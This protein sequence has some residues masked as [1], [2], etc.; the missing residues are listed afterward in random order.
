MTSQ[1][2]PTRIIQSL[3]EISDGY[4]V[5][6]CDLWGCFHNGIT[7]FAAAVAALQAYRARGGIV[8]LLTN[9]P[10]PGPSVLRQ[11]AAMRAPEDAWD[12]I[13][14][15]GDAT[16]AEIASGK[17]GKRLHVVGPERDESI[18]DGLDIE[19]VALEKADSILC[20]GLFDDE[21]ET[22][23]DY[24]DLIAGGVARG[25]PMLCANPDIIVDR[26]ERRLYCAGAIAQKY[27][28]AE[29]QVVYFGKPHPP[30]YALARTRAEELAGRPVDPARILAVGDG[31]ATD[32]LGAEQARLDCIFVSGGLAS[33]DVGQD[34]EH[35]DQSLL[36]QYLAV[37]SR[38]PRYTIGRL[39]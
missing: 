17:Y 2:A 34:P 23:A 20:T 27:A 36:T 7:P 24:A 19:L 22:P 13:V 3:A 8:V 32:V 10:R 12:G 15:S 16:R 39:R 21:T 38:A 30:I 31:I 25:I 18:W 28:E 4:D 26:G 9:A 14:S 35:P 37:H 5:L 33:R 6:L 29:G 1:P 11:L